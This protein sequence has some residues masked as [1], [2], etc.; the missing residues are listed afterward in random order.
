M[1]YDTINFKNMGSNLVYL[2]G[3]VVFGV[4]ILFLSLI[5]SQSER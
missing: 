2:A 3:Y 1:G 5:K 4:F